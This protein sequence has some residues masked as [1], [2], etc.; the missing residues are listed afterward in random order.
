MARHFASSAEQHYSRGRLEVQDIRRLS[1]RVRKLLRSPAD[2]DEAAHTMIVLS[3]V[4]GAYHSDR[5]AMENRPLRKPPGR[6]SQRALY[7]LERQFIRAC[8]VKPRSP[9]AQ[10]KIRSVWR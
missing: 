4:V 10:R 5:V 3:S 6:G 2:C 1:D 8:V 7:G 9:A